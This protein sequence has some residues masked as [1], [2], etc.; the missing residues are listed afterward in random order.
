MVWYE[1]FCV[2]CESDSGE[3]HGMIFSLL[4]ESVKLFVHPLLRNGISCTPRG[5]HVA[6]PRLL[7]KLRLGN[8]K[9]ILKIAC[10]LELPRVMRKRRVVLEAR[11]LRGV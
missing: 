7:L 8:L 6:S 1:N 5:A 3:L 11:G 2:Y 9:L 4:V 10:A